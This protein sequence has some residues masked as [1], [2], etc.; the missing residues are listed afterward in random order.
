MSADICRALVLSGGGNNGAWEVGVLWGLTHYG[1]PADYAYDVISGVSA[2]S[3]N[4]A[5]LVGWPIGTEVGA[6]E[7]LSDEWNSITTSDIWVE[8]PGG[9]LAGLVQ[10]GAVDNSPALAFM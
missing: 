3:I 10:Q 1:N 2:G 9:P 6:T 8:W 7:W 5:G 4:T